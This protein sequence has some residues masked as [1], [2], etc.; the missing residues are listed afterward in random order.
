MAIPRSFDLQLYSELR[1]QKV[2]VYSILCEDN[3]NRKKE[4]YLTVWPMSLFH[5]SCV[6]ISLYYIYM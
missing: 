1:L 4:V 6:L 5:K 2:R 3:A